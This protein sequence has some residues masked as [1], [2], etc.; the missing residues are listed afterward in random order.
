MI[1]I[2]ITGNSSVGMCMCVSVCVCMC[3]RELLLDRLM[4]LFD[5]WGNEAY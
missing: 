5:I 2:I 3:V 4:D 1:Y